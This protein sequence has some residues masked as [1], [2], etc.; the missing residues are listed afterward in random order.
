MAVARYFFRIYFVLI[1]C[2]SVGDVRAQEKSMVQIKAFDQQMNAM[3]NI[4]VS[5]NGKEFFSIEGKK[6]VFHDVP[7]D[8]LPPK[9]IRITPAEWEAESWNYS[10]GVLEIMIRKKLYVVVHVKV[11]TGDRKPLTNLAVSFKGKK[12]LAAQTNGRGELELPL[13]LDEQITSA[14]QFLVTGH[15][16]VALQ[17]TENGK[18]LV[19]ETLQKKEKHAEPTTFKDF[20]LARLDSIRSLTVFYAVFKN[21]DFDKLDE[22]T[23]RKIDEKFYTLVNQLQQ[24]AKPKA[25]IGKISDSSFVKN[26]VANLLAQARLEN[27]MLDDFR[28]DFDKKILIINQKLAGGT[29]NLRGADRERLVGDLL[30]LEKVLEQNEDKF[31]KNISDYRIILSSLK[32]SFSDIQVLEDKLSAS[33]RKLVEEQRVF[34]TKI[35]LAVSVALIFATLVIYLIMLRDRVEKQKRSL[36]KANDEVKN[37]N[38]NLA[39]IVYERSKLLLEAYRELDIF[40]YRASHDLRSPICTVIGLCNIAEHGEEDR[41]DMIRKISDT[42]VKMDGMLK[43]L[44]M[45]SEVNHPDNYSDVHLARKIQHVI[46]NFSTFISRNNIEVLIDCPDDMRFH[47]YP[48]LIEIILHNLVENALFFS[49]VRRDHDAKISVKAT[50]ENNQLVLMVHDNGIGIDDDVRLRLGDMFFVGHEYS[51]GNGLGLYIVRKSVQSLNGKIEVQTKSNVFTLFSVTIPVNASTTSMIGRLG[52]T[53]QV[54]LEAF[55]HAVS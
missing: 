55:E 16:V 40:L 3:S 29:A 21:Y 53:T 35:V 14:D 26:D 19:L 48:G 28:N 17:S 18:V 10:R 44:R 37:I 31:Y 5:I 41:L 24:P 33:E 50:L 45:M 54:H 2:L 11:E 22:I 42:A 47:S 49:A 1:V 6:P 9:F 20:D 30:S 38:E 4:S 8:D 25:F 39:G 13:A 27:T 7:K 34:R 43:K 15:R 36:E 32:A 46:G 23:R 51:K 52:E 12:S